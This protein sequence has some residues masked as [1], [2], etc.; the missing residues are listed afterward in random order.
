MHILPHIFLPVLRLLD[1][2]ERDLL[3]SDVGPMYGLERGVLKQ[4]ASVHLKRF[5]SLRE[6]GEL[7]SHVGSQ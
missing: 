5:K 4:F 6:S 2:R 1:G 7:E 3:V